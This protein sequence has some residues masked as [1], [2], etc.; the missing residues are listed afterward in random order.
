MK[1]GNLT[2]GGYLLILSCLNTVLANNPFILPKFVMFGDSITELSA[3]SLGG[4]F[5]AF[6]QLQNDYVRRLEVVNRGFK[7]YTTA[8]AKYMINRIIEADTADGSDINLMTVF[9]GSNDA[10]I[11]TQQHVPLKTFKKN[12][13]LITKTALHRGI[14]VI[15]IG[16]GLVDQRI[17]FDRSLE[18]FWS[19]N[20]AVKEVADDNDVAFVDMYKAFSNAMGYKGKHPMN[21][22]EFNKFNSTRFFVDGL[23][24]TGEA[25]TILYD[26]VIDNIRIRYPES[27]P[28]NI[29]YILPTSWEVNNYDIERSLYSN[30][31]QLLKVDVMMF[32]F[33]C[34]S[35]VFY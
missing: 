28:V 1:F 11:N 2:I 16:P 27:D 8:W 23:H 22:T 25:Y 32:I 31:S 6:S 30:G 7:G 21:Q 9:F 13:E 17:H 35:F 26:Q 20:R 14:K 15:L 33:V 19:Y 4:Q 18:N 5:S 10:A 3:A 24:F 34:I 12:I 29:K